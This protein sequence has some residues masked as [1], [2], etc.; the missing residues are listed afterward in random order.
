MAIKIN[1]CFFAESDEEYRKNPK[2]YRGFV[3][4]YSRTMEFFD[5]NG[6]PVAA[7][8]KFGVILEFTIR[9]GKK[10]FGFAWKDGTAYSLFKKPGL[11]SIKQDLKR[12]SRTVLEKTV[13]TRRDG[14]MFSAFPDDEYWYK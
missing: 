14:G 4:R 8:N 7:I 6:A 2:K 5:K 10:E 13:D 1:G 9:N 12:I 11:L 3:K